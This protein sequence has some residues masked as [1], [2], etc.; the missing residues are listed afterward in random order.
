[1]KAQ[2]WRNVFWLRR[3][4]LELITRIP[5]TC[6]DSSTGR[7]A[8]LKALHDA[9]RVLGLEY[10]NG[11]SETGFFTRRGRQ[12]WSQSLREGSVPGIRCATVHEAKGHEY[13]AVCLVIPPIRAPFNQT[14]QIFEVWE[15]RAN[16]EPK[17]V[18]YVGTTRAKKL[19]AVA[20]PSTYRNRI[21]AILENNDIPWEFSDLTHLQR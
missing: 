4:A 14:E 7:D 21:A 1:M 19:V 3:T 15:R 16:G 2:F 8:W 5:T 18:A 17:R 6:D 12:N 11:I 10:L 9:I 20:V 13:D